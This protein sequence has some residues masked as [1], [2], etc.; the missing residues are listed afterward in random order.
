MFGKHLMS[1][2]K[3]LNKLSYVQ[4]WAFLGPI[5]WISSR[6]L[7][8]KCLCP[9]LLMSQT[10]SWNTVWLISLSL[11]S[12][13]LTRQPSEAVHPVYVKTFIWITLNFKREVKYS[14]NNIQEALNYDYQL[15]LLLRGIKDM[16]ATQWLGPLTPPLWCSPNWNHNIWWMFWGLI[17]LWVKLVGFCLVEPWGL[18]RQCIDPGEAQETPAYIQWQSCLSL[19]SCW[20]LLYL[21]MGQGD[22]VWI[23]IETGAEFAQPRLTDKSSEKPILLS[24]RMQTR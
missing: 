20:W 8:S 4:R 12:R 3:M 19:K 16:W 5:H 11:V 14:S 21:S 7:S 24:S 6:G 2:K 18:A 23:G 1:S 15:L 17:F 10:G 9:G 22:L 13:S